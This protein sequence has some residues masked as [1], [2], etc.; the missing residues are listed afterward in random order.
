MVDKYRGIMPKGSIWYRFSREEMIAFLKDS[1]DLVPKDT[2]IDYS[3][4]ESGDMQAINVE[5]MESA[6]AKA[7]LNIVTLFD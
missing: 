1:T 4:L 6:I 3:L 2:V 7:K 5:G